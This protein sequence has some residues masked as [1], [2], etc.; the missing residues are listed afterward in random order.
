M[1]KTATVAKGN[2][3]Y[4]ARITASEICKECS[5]RDNV[6]GL[7]NIDR[8]RIVKIETN[9]VEPYT[10]EIIS[11]A[12]TYNAPY[13]I[14]H[15]CNHVCH[16]GRKFGCK[17]TAKKGDTFKATVMFIHS[18]EEAEKAKEQIIEILSDGKIT[19]D[20]IDLLDKSISQLNETMTDIINLRIALEK[21]KIN[22]R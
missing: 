16:I 15:F 20:E 19:D 13:L 12:K 3:Y 2:I 10:D 22:R 11:M 7:V 9:Q 18:L 5:N 21:E 4:E 1:S 8:N 14:E 17:Y 6:S